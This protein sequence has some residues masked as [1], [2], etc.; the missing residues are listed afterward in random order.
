MES[1]LVIMKWV[2]NPQKTIMPMNSMNINK[3][4]ISITEIEL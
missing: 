3:I 1:H 2:L 4:I